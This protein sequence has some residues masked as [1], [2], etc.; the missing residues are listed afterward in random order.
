M[1]S[2]YLKTGTF[3]VGPLVHEPDLEAL[4]EEGHHLQPLDHGLGPELDLLEDGRVR[5]EGH[6]GSGAAP[7]RG[8]SHLQLPHRLTAVLERQHVVI[9]VLIDLEDQL[10]RQRVHYRHANTMETARDLVGASAKFP[11]SVQHREHDFGCGLTRIMRMIF[12]GDATSVIDDPTA[13]IR[14]NRDIDSCAEA[15]H[16]FVHRI[17]DNFPDQVVQSRRPG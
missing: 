11:S 9:T 1:P 4:V 5:P 16:G 14:Q 8:T 6:R 10:G 7:R 2:L 17:I 15:S 3:A 12:D 13:P